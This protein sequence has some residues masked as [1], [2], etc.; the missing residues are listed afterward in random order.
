VVTVTGLSLA[1]G[2]TYALTYSDATAPGAAATSGCATEAMTAALRE[3]GT[4]ITRYDGPAA[5]LTVDS[6]TGKSGRQPA[7]EI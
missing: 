3:T 7:S 2:Q 6:W 4:A 5:R 1:A